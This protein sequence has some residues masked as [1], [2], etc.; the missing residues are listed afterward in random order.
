MKH[1]GTTDG[2]RCLVVGD[3]HGCYVEL[4]ALLDQVGL[5]E[6]DEVVAL[7][8]IVDRG[9]E[10]GKVLRQFGWVADADEQTTGVVW[11]GVRFGTLLG[12]HERK[13]VRSYRGEF[14]PALS[15]HLTRQSIGEAAYPSA[16]RFMQQ[17]PQYRIVHD[18]LLIHGFLQPGV[19]LKDQAEIYLTGVM[20]G[21]TKLKE[22][23]GDPWSWYS[24]Y[25]GE[26]HL[27]VGHHHYGEN[28]A[29]ITTIRN[30]VRFHGIDTR[31]CR[32]GRLTGLV[33]PSFE[34]VEVKAAHD[35][36]E[37]A[38]EAHGRRPKPEEKPVTEIAE[39]ELTWAEVDELLDFARQDG[40]SDA[41]IEHAR[42]ASKLVDAADAKLQ[43]TVDRVSKRWDA[44]LVELR[45]RHGYGDLGNERERF[46]CF[47]GAAKDL[48]EADLL[49]AAR[50]GRLGVEKLRKGYCGPGEVLTP[51]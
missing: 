6:G 18:S 8:D 1:R 26:R 42:A 9:P 48:P 45:E 31:C 32:G 40:A 11:H 22:A 15:Q 37:L 3:I 44:L 38:L 25:E 7:G 30:G 49:R 17:L 47:W 4:N 24:H 27:V 46:A 28:G 5:V 14:A 39:D 36:W 33:L 13:H 19:P 20:S 51:N 23:I 43:A 12:N 29:F 35:Y 2:C 21:E 16:V 50:S 41:A 34:V 10:S